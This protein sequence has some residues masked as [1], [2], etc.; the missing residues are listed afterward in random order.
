MHIVYEKQQSKLLREE[1]LR[2]LLRKA[3]QGHH[4]MP[5]QSD[6]TTQPQHQHM[7]TLCAT[8]GEVSRMPSQ[9]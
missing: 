7:S 1:A 9:D 4:K 3:V 6:S 5:L 8:S 2:S